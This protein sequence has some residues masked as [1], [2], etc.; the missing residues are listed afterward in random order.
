MTQ[1]YPLYDSLVAKVEARKE[2][3]INIKQICTTIINLSQTLPVE[4]AKK[5]YDEIAALILHHEIKS[6]GGIILSPVP[7][8]AKV[9]ID[10]KGLLYVMMNLPPVLQQILAQYIEESS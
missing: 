9:M 7:Y 8:E 10:N 3:G 5:H 2:K 1:P 4:E 6:N